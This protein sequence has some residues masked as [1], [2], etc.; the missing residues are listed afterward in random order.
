LFDGGGDGQ[1]GEKNVVSG[2]TSSVSGGYTNEA[3]KLQSSVSGGV[4]ARLYKTPRY[5]LGLP[6]GSYAAGALTFFGA[7]GAPVPMWAWLPVF[8]GD[9]ARST[10]LSPALLNISERLITSAPDLS[11]GLY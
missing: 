6:S 8:L 11:M 1:R 7:N 2:F 10:S 3:S 5:R 9:E 4:L